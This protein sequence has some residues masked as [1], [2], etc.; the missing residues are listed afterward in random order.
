MCKLSDFRP[1][2]LEDLEIAQASLRKLINLMKRE[3]VF[4]GKPDRLDNATFREARKRLR[5]QASLG[6]RALAVL[7][8]PHGIFNPA[9]QPAIH[10]SSVNRFCSDH[11][12]E[13][14]TTK[15]ALAV[16]TK[17]IS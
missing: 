9:S 1:K 6:G 5:R 2:A 11:G 13:I 7:A 10:E 12:V 8:F 14:V 4:L 3:A 16:V 17:I 15:V